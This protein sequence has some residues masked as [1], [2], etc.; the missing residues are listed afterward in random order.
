MEVTYTISEQE[1]IR[2]TK[3]RTKRAGIGRESKVK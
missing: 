1:Y 2:A 3:L